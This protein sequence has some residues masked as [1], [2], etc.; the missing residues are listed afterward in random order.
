MPGPSE[1]SAVRH[2]SCSRNN[3]DRIILRLSRPLT[4]VIVLL[5]CSTPLQADSFFDQLIDPAD[6]RFDTSGWLIDNSGFLPVP[7]IITEPA[8]GSG[9]GLA[10]VFFHGSEEQAEER[11]RALEGGQPDSGTPLLPPSVS[12]VFAAATENG[13][14][15]AGGA[16]L[17]VWK[18]DHVRLY[19][20][21]AACPVATGVYAYGRALSFAA[22]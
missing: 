13:T 10:G 7:I 2:G 3:T 16:H 4:A 5:L 12:V 11:K 17:G 21:R 8:V 18:Q 15:L 22:M 20:Q 1:P 14:W 9:L 19:R 6:G